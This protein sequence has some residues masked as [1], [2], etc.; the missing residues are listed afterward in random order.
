MLSVETSETLVDSE[1]EYPAPMGHSA[2]KGTTFLDRKF[3]WPQNRH[4]T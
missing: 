1:K 2:G 4:I 3:L